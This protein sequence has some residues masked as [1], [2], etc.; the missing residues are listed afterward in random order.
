MIKFFKKYYLV[1]K[2][3]VIYLNN[4]FIKKNLT[5]NFRM[6]FF[7]RITINSA[8]QLMSL[9][10]PIF[11][12]EF[13]GMN[14]QL[15]LLYYLINDFLFFNLISSGCR[16]IMNRIGINRSLQISIFWGI[17]YYLF[18]FLLEQYIVSD[19]IWWLLP[20]ILFSLLFRLSHWI[21]YHVCVAKLTDQNI[22]GSQFSLMEAG[23][24]I[25]GAILPFIGGL[26]LN[27]FG[28]NYLFLLAVL[29][30]FSA[31][32]FFRQLP[33]VEERF[34]WSYKKTW[35][36]FL[37][38]KMR[39][40]IL[41]YIGEGAEGIAKVVVW[42]VF[43]WQ[44]LE[45]NYLQVG[46]ITSII[47]I[48]TIII[49]IMVGDL[50]DKFPNRQSW[51]RYSSILHSLAWLFK[52]III[53]PFQI[54]IFSTYYNISRMLAV[55]SLNTLHYD[56]ASGQGHYVDEYTVIREKAVVLGRVIMSLLSIIL[57]IFFPIYY[58]FI[59]AAIFSLFFSFLKKGERYKD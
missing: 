52:A 13:L 30:Y 32:F 47:V 4:R 55:T 7:S 26:I 42:P 21:P 33:K 19:Y 24:L 36:N 54:F 44:I 5:Y 49:Q 37:A 15:V 10:L 51:L 29:I 59:L 50:M 58:I 6:I 22:R 56:I 3:K 35:Q 57:L 46:G 25:L 48:T 41:A 45:G 34:S 1:I 17:F 23:I 8:A 20:T 38:K 16:Y 53:N 14:L 27:F 28:Y 31:S 9:F 43:I 40:N 11:L 18:F 2:N 12:Y 39:F